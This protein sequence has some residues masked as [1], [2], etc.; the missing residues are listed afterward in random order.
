MGDGT[1][2]GL[3]TAGALPPKSFQEVPSRVAEIAHIP[4]D[5][6]SS[7]ASALDSVKSTGF[8]AADALEEA[9]TS[10]CMGHLILAGPPGTG[11]TSLAK[12]LAAAFNAELMTETANPEWS[13]YDTIGTQ[14]LEAG[15]GAAPRHGL[16]TNA[17][18]QCASTMVDNFDTGEGPQA[19]WLLIDEMNRADIDRAFGP[20]FT[21]LA[22]GHTAGMV[23]DY[24]DGRPH[25]ALP[26]RFRI[27]A[28]VNEYDTRF[29]N[30]MSGALRRRFSKVVI[31]PPPNESDSRSSAEEWKVASSA[32]IERATFNLGSAPA[33]A[34]TTL[35]SNAA[36]DFRRL[37]GFVRSAADGAVPVGTAQI[38]DVAEYF[39]TLTSLASSPDTADH[40]P[41]ID[42]ALVARL[43]PGL[44]TDST[45]SRLH[46]GYIASL[47]EL[48]PALPRF[49]ERMEAFLNGLD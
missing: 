5:L 35:L 20:L 31:L 10:L 9:I 28:T 1:L 14:T 32:A 47:Q 8:F 21:A 26:A 48:F 25:V 42:R 36:G 23:L 33:L 41:L 12:A 30:A 37:F 29:V 16:V 49:R 24:M 3:A 46:S 19:K 4:L 40:W 11:K 43:L 6:P 34:S 22:G 27:I 15:G 2:S 44:E 7:L 18:L 45:R 39:L 38:I 13:V 17:V